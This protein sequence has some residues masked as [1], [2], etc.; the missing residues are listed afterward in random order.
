VT[1]VLLIEPCAVHLVL[2]QDSDALLVLWLLWNCICTS[3]LCENF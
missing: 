3:W 2:C 1:L